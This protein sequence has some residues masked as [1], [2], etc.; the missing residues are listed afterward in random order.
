ML[1]SPRALPYS[2]FQSS[3]SHPLLWLLPQST[4]PLLPSNF[5]SSF[6]SIGYY[7]LGVPQR[8]Q[9][10]MSR[11]YYSPSLCFALLSLGSPLSPFWF[12]SQNIRNH[13]CFFSPPISSSFASHKVLKDNHTTL[14]CSCRLQS[15]SLDL[16][17]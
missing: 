14:V 12:P 4:C 7:H 9:L 6:L 15:H 8:F 2:S 11:W 3:H 16:V 10:F 5:R 1:V 17:L 13:L